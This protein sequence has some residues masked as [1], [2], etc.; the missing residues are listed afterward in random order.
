MDRLGRMTTAFF[1]L[2]LYRFCLTNRFC[3]ESLPKQNPVRGKW[4]KECSEP[5]R[6]LN[7]RDHLH[8]DA[9][10]AGEPGSDRLSSVTAHGGVSK[11]P[12]AAK[13]PKIS[14]PHK[15]TF[16]YNCGVPR[17][18]SCGIV[19]FSIL[20]GAQEPGT[21]GTRDAESAKGGWQH[22]SCPPKSAQAATEDDVRN[23]V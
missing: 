13:S 4:W 12:P 23:S 21:G 3:L 15:N 17:G 14:P 11:L 18:T 5:S 22:P 6:T 2:A 16:W 8:A 9:D 1:M 7:Q 10:A 20:P 19:I